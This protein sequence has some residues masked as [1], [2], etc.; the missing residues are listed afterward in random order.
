MTGPADAIF[1]TSTSRAV[2]RWQAQ[3]GMPQDSV[4]RRG[5]LV[6]M[7]VLPTAVFLDSEV[8]VGS[9]LEAG[10]AA[11]RMVTGPPTFTITLTRE[12]AELIPLS[13]PVRVK[14]SA[15]LWEG[16][17]GSTVALPSGELSMTL[18]APDG[19]SLCGESCS[20][21][22]TVGSESLFTGSCDASVGG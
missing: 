3:L 16:V 9:Q 22:V 21:L 1:S 8:V 5:D 17:V 19:G 15:G 6:Y 18:T 11:V 4:V 10:G 12:Q 13:S 2:A 7:P 14:H 20:E